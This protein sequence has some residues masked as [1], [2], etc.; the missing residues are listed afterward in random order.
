MKTLIYIFIFLLGSG[1]VATAGSDFEQSMARGKA[2]YEGYCIACHQGKGEGVPGVFPPLAKADYLMN[3][4]ENAARAIK[5]G[6]QGEIVVN[7]ITYNNYMSELGLSDQEV[8]DVMT[9]IM[10]SWGNTYGKAIT[11]DFVAKVKPE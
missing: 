3:S 6:Q 1:L 8:A 10:N 2:I 5:Y 11:T 9:Y 4:P 7:G